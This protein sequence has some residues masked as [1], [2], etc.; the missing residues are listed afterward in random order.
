MWADRPTSGFQERLQS[1]HSI[2]FSLV[3]MSRLRWGLLM[4]TCTGCQC[5]QLSPLYITALAYLQMDP[6]HHL[7]RYMFDQAQGVFLENCQLN[8][9]AGDFR[10]THKTINVTNG[11]IDGIGNILYNHV[12]VDAMH[13]SI[14]RCDAPRCCRMTREAVQ[15]DI[16]GWITWTLHHST[17][18]TDI[19]WLTGAAGT[20]KTAIAQTIAESCAR[21]GILA[22]TFFFSFRSESTNNY[23]RFVPTIA[24]Q[25][26]I[27]VP[28]AREPIGAAVAND[29]AVVTKD[30][31]SQLETL[32]LHP[33]S[34]ARDSEG[35]PTGTWPKV[36]IIDGLDECGDERQQA[37]VLRVL[38]GAL[39]SLHFP[40]RILLASRP[41]KEMRRYFAGPG[42][43]RTRVIHLDKDYDAEAEIELYL[44]SSF[45]SIRREHNIQH[46]W[47]TDADL[48]KLVQNAS[49]QFIYA[50][51]VLN[52][53]NRRSCQ[54]ED[55]LQEI[56]DL[57]VDYR[58]DHPLSPLD[59]LYVAIISKCPDPFESVL[60][61]RI[62]H[63]LQWRGSLPSAAH[64]NHFF[65]Y[66]S[67]QW[68]RIFD[69]LH[70]LLLIP[71][72]ED[73]KS[74]YKV[75]H[76]S[77]V[78]F[79]DSGTSRCVKVVHLLKETRRRRSACDASTLP[80]FLPSAISKTLSSAGC[81]RTV[82][83][84]GGLDPLACR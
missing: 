26:A 20:G 17:D 44:R 77:F 34:A 18:P 70:S 74:N 15:D 9:V 48:Q 84:S 39:E 10:V 33:L 72:F 79:L 11:S 63:E 54:P 67:A 37:V 76:K 21:R 36:I 82:M 80:N 56:L 2:L 4:L 32:I 51:T 16:I 12:A 59:A 8:S 41:E 5:Q 66:T 28:G 78:D 57:R 27:K 31:R 38:H 46:R 43:S 7:S 45:N 65:G 42:K 69:Q 55:S 1:E 29:F 61:I 47:P 83:S 60:A 53:V 75:F 13:D 25:L 71:A 73:R 3:Q 35:S 81:L 22:A 40:F 23:D 58:G 6:R 62:I 68:A 24:Y 30:L 50:T 52:Y 14:R 49:R 64:Y 19:L